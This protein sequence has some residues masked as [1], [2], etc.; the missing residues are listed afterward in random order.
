[1]PVQGARQIGRKLKGGSHRAAMLRN[2]VTSLIKHERIKTTLPRAKEL[3]RVADK[4]VT[5]GKMQNQH[6]EIQAGKVVREKAAIRKLFG[7]IAP[8]YQLRPGG[9]TR[10]LKIGNR[11][12]DGAPMAVIEFV[13]REGEVRPAKPVSREIYVKATTYKG[14][15]LKSLLAEQE[16]KEEQA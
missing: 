1:M 3:S 4:M 13:D 10:V 11:R 9:Y 16:G 2:M 12:G 14:N 7:E 5:F 6:G 8:R 15:G